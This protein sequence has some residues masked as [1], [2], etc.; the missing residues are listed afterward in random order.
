ME[1]MQDISDGIINHAEATFIFPDVSGLGVI[2][3][4]DLMAVISALPVPCSPP[5]PYSGNPCDYPLLLETAPQ[6]PFFGSI[7]PESYALAAHFTFNQM[8]EGIWTPNFATFFFPDFNGDGI[9]S[10]ADLLAGLEIVPVD[11]SE[12]PGEPALVKPETTVGL[13]SLA[14]KKLNKRRNDI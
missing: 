2:N 12:L 6:S 7:S 11:C 14:I 8:G 13:E 5:P 4:A 3:V 9:I 1:V 10:A